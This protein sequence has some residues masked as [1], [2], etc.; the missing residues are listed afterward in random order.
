MFRLIVVELQYHYCN[1]DR[2]VDAVLVVRLNDVASIVFYMERFL[3]A[4]FVCLNRSLCYP[5]GCQN[6]V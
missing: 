3:N 1:T 4:D 6:F 5:Y 2:L